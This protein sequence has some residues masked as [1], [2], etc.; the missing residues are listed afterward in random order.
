MPIVEIEAD[1]GDCVV[2]GADANFTLA[3]NNGVGI[4]STGETLAVGMFKNAGATYYIY[5]LFLKF[6]TTIIP[7][8][9]VINSLKLRLTCIN[10]YSE[11]REFDIQV[12]EQDWSSQ[13]PIAAGNQDAA[14]DG[15]LAGSTAVAWRNTSGISVNTPYESPALTA[16]YLNFLGDTYYSL[17]SQY[18]YSGS[19]PSTGNERID[20]GSQGNTTAAYRP[21]LVVDYS[22]QGGIPATFLSDYGIF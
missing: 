12:V 15:C 3:R 20:I 5:R 9:A 18:D 19:A 10:D 14:Y 21:I 11:I 7:A 1:S 8:S 2:Y 17:R 4:G 16:A 13:D 22:I 6:D